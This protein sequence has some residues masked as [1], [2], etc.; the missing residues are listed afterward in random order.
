MYV[1]FSFFVDD[2]FSSRSLDPI[3][4]E[5]FNCLMLAREEDM[6]LERRCFHSP[7]AGI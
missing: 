1:K 7:H 2:F 4:Y 5:K 6:R 3:Y